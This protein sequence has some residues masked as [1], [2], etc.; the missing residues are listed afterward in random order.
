MSDLPVLRHQLL[1]FFEEFVCKSSRLP[2]KTFPIQLFYE[3]CYIPHVENI[4]KRENATA[5]NVIPLEQF[6]TKKMILP[7]VRLFE[8]HGLTYESKRGTTTLSFD[9]RALNKF[10][11]LQQAPCFKNRHYKTFFDAFRSGAEIYEEDVCKL[12]LTTRLLVEEYY[13]E[14]GGTNVDVEGA[15]ERL[16][17]GHADN[18]DVYALISAGRLTVLS[19]ESLT[20]R[21][22]RQVFDG[23]S[24]HIDLVSDHQHNFGD[25]YRARGRKLRH[26]WKDLRKQVLY[27]STHFV[28]QH[29]D[30]KDYY[31][32]IKSIP[33]VEK[34][35]NAY[36]DKDRIINF[37]VH[38]EQIVD[39]DAYPSV[40][41]PPCVSIQ[42]LLLSCY[43]QDIGRH[44]PASEFAT[45]LARVVRI[46]FPE[47]FYVTDRHLAEISSNMNPF[48]RWA[49]TNYDADCVEY[50]GAVGMIGKGVFR[51]ALEE[52][53]GISCG[54]REDDIK[55]KYLLHYK[56]SRRDVPKLLPKKKRALSGDD[57]VG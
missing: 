18:K 28:T 7:L 6:R 12:G 3:Q 31:S 20:F 22:S 33:G 24:E 55:A 5:K 40:L 50:T 1:Y 27:E 13:K 39:L 49:E 25:H 34:A 43:E 16:S 17:L 30:V 9:F 35:I 26:A 44:F 56:M 4:Q 21:I 53:Y 57:V 29:G 11:A 46:R 54:H 36:M 45:Q 48:L 51:E 37:F 15:E 32:N 47:S 10:I 23:I 41:R 42:K 8:G 2:P 14:R 52:A 38:G 19:I